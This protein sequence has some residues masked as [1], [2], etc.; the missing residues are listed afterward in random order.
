MDD[1]EKTLE[2]KRTNLKKLIQNAD[3]A[4]RREMLKYEEAELY[5]RLQSECFNLYPVVVKALSLQI[6]N[7][8]KRE[9]FC[10]IL[11]GHKL[12]DVAAAHGM[13]PE[14]A[15]QEFNRAVWNLNKKVNNGAFTAKE[16]VNIQLLHERNM[17]KNKVLDYDRQ[18]HQLELENKKL[19]D[20]VNILLK[21]K[22][23]YTKYKLE[24]MHETEQVVQE[25]ATKKHIE[26]QE[27]P[28]HTSIIMRCVQWLKKVYFQL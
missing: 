16:S 14:Q 27:S 22:K 12:K 15:G 6:T 28:K 17:L 23:R 3:K 19:S 1:L 21:E 24:I 25:Q 18:Y 11:N 4:I 20:Q 8:R 5:I 13:S 9:V 2:L 10:S 7:D 26:K